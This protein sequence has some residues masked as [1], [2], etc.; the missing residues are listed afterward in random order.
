MSSDSP[1][2]G[3]RWLLQPYKALKDPFDPPKP[4]GGYRPVR[5]IEVR[6]GWVRYWMSS[7]YPDERKETW[8]FVGMYNRVGGDDER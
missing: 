1:K 4:K 7:L 3:E 6:D 5:I 8:L 2:A